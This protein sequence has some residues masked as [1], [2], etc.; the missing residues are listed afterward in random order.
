MKPSKLRFSSR[1]SWE[2]KVSLEFSPIHSS[3]DSS[4]SSFI[5]YLRSTSFHFNRISESSKKKKTSPHVGF[6][7]FTRVLC[8]I[9]IV[10]MWNLC[11]ILFFVQYKKFTLSFIF[12]SFQ[13]QLF[14]FIHNV[15]V[16]HLRWTNEHFLLPFSILPWI[17]E[18]HEKN[19]AIEN[20]R[21]I[22]HAQRARSS[23]VGITQSE[24]FFLITIHSIVYRAR[25]VE[26]QKNVCAVDV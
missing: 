23:F 24:N 7:L 18:I 19:D 3:R 17:V 5:F 13:N 9:E 14:T 22:Y 25:R 20:V 2:W 11:W 21:I 26:L 6:H 16:M 1:A 10:Q 4:S 15:L 12:L 8:C